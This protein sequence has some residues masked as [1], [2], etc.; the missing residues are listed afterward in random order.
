[1]KKVVLLLTVLALLC[2][3]CG[4]E[5]APNTPP[6]PTA[7]TTAMIT[8]ATT[9]ATDPTTAATTTAPTVAAEDLGRLV[10]ADLFITLAGVTVY[11]GDDATPLLTALGEA[12]SVEESVPGGLWP[13]RYI[14]HTFSDFVVDAVAYED[15]CEIYQFYTKSSNY[16]LYKGTP[17]GC[18]RGELYERYGEPTYTHKYDVTYSLEGADGKPYGVRFDF[19]AEN[20]QG[21]A[22]PSDTVS[23]FAILTNAYSWGMKP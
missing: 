23:A 4:C 18:T 21:P 15:K 13:D 9:V 3:L 20:T 11:P 19:V 10:P 6:S 1:M 22:Q 16:P 2:G 8:T 7:V 12:E 5:K 17:I 14:S